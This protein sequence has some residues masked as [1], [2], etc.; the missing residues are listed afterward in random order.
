MFLQRAEDD[1]MPIMRNAI[2]MARTRS[3][4]AGTCAWLLI[5][6]LSTAGIFRFGVIEVM[7]MLAPLAVVPLALQL[8]ALES[9]STWA[10][11]A[12]IRLQPLAAAFA[13]LSF[14]IDRGVVAAG[15]T[16]PWIAVTGLVAL[17]GLMRFWKHRFAALETMALSAAMLLLPVGGAWL[18]F[19][20]LGQNP[21]TF[22]EPIVLLTAV[23]F[24]YTAFAAPLLAVLISRELLRALP[25]LRPVAC[26]AIIAL[27]AAT[28]LLAA[29]FVF[30][31]VLKLIAALTLVCAV[32]LLSTLLTMLLIALD[33]LA[34]KVMLAISACSGMAGMALAAVY[35]AGEFS[36]RTLIT[37]PQMA[38]LHGIINGVGMVFCGL[39]GWMCHSTWKGGTSCCPSSKE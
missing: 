14:F 34:V 23:H 13:V 4:V 31:P 19:S 1:A 29:G 28:P 5:C 37:I 12:S 27:L 24:H 3:A 39:C 18:F 6:A 17:A 26:G 8:I 35:E 32:T 30:S 21:T 10:L 36:G 11:H 15:L 20:R 38:M 33:S 2:L 22:T 25:G 7:F 16:L 9:D